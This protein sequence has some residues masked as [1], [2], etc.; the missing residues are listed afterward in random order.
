M[1]S[2]K[3]HNGETEGRDGVETQSRETKTV[4]ESERGKQREI[5]KETEKTRISLAMHS[6][7]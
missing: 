4:T 1:W 5:E 7:V 3:M 6:V 2:V